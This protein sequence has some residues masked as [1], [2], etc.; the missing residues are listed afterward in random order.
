MSSVEEYN[1]EELFEIPW[2]TTLLHPKV[3]E[4]ELF[5]NRLKKSTKVADTE[6]TEMWTRERNIRKALDTIYDLTRSSNTAHNEAL[7]RPLK[8]LYRKLLRDV[9]DI[10]IEN[11]ADADSD[12][13][14][15]PSPN[16]ADKSP[17]EQPPSQPIADTESAAN[18]K[19]PDEDINE[20]LDAGSQAKKPRRKRKKMHLT[21]SNRLLKQTPSQAKK[22]RKK[23]KK[24]HQG[25]CPLKS[26]PRPAKINKSLMM[27]ILLRGR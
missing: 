27:K 23:R 19:Y 6:L 8:F 11:F 7:W 15:S 26:T 20:F 24:E 17:E 1:M 13:S 4:W 18:V 10:F 2:F 12:K 3:L 9:E 14:H 25:M 22:P 16:L 5:I 21:D